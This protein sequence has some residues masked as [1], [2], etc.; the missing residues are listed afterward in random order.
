MPFREPEDAA[1]EGSP[2][3]ILIVLGDVGLAHLDC[4]GG[5]GGIVE[6]PNTTRLAASG[7]RYSNFHTPGLPTAARS[8]MLT[9][10]NH[11]S[12]A[13]G[14]F[15]EAVT[16]TPAIRAGYRGAMGSCPRSFWIEATTRSR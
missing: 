5:L 10:R 12:N 13:M 2:N 14:A 9:G 15:P 6:T 4:F 8:C 1:P 11:H 3:V 7:L 16:A